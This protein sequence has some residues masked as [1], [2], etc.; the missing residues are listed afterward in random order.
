L[1]LRPSLP[2]SRTIAAAGAPESRSEDNKPRRCANPSHKH[3][4]LVL[5]FIR[6]ELL[7]RIRHGHAF[8]GPFGETDA[9]LHAKHQRLVTIPI[10]FYP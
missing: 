3:Y 10:I 7:I 6:N 4:K 1:R 8:D 2:K 9:S 5:A